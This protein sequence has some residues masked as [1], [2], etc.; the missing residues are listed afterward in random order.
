MYAVTQPC[1]GVAGGVSGPLPSIAG[2][3]M[4]YCFYFTHPRCVCVHMCTGNFP[5]VLIG[6]DVYVVTAATASV[7]NFTVTDDDTGVSVGIVGGTPARSSLTHTGSAY[8]FAWTPASPGDV[9]GVTF[10]ATD[11]LGASGILRPTTY[12]C[13]CLNGGTCANDGIF[14]S[15][16]NITVMYCNCPPGEPRLL[17]ATPYYTPPPSSLPPPT[18]SAL[19]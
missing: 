19:W 10:Y 8:M 3:V 5:P 7:Y 2:C 4:L 14:N 6:S 13:P 15:T 16:R 9:N 1:Q 12:L 18:L 17:P 11:S